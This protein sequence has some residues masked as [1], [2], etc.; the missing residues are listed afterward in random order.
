MDR[1]VFPVVIRERRA[2]DARHSGNVV[3]DPLDSLDAV[4]A[5][6]HAHVDKR[7]QV[8]VASRRGVGGHRDAFLTLIGRFEDDAQ[9]RASRRVLDRL[10]SEQVAFP[11]IDL[12]RFRVQTLEDL[13]EVPV[14]VPVVVDHQDFAVGVHQERSVARG[15]SLANGSINGTKFVSGSGSVCSGRVSVN[16]APFPAPLLDTRMVPPISSIAIAAECSPKPLPLV[17]VVKPN[18]K[19]CLS[20]SSE[21]PQPVSETVMEACSSSWRVMIFRVCDVRSVAPIASTAFLIK[22]SSTCNSFDFS[23]VIR[24]RLTKSRSTVTPCLTIDGP[25]I[26]SRSSIKP[27][28]SI[29]S[30]KHTRRV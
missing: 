13:L 27:C 25:C 12:R 26:A 28:T 20:W 7:Q 6:G 21:I 11:L 29:D 8:R 18:R 16:V 14:D 22:L 17:L 23:R 15:A 3:P 24:G 10:H 30:L 19:I 9:Q 5:R 4:D 2:D 1:D